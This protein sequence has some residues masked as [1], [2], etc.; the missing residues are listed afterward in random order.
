MIF[1]KKLFLHA[2]QEE[3]GAPGVEQYEY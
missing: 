1:G 2:A 3:V